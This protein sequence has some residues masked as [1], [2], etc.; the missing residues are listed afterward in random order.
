VLVNANLACK[1]ADF[2]LSRELDNT[3]DS[4][5]ETQVSGRSFLNAGQLK[6][7]LLNSNSWW[8]CKVG[9]SKSTL[10]LYAGNVF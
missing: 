7:E 3:E 10:K 6:T 9:M 8:C 2:G 4:E 1:V 5:Y